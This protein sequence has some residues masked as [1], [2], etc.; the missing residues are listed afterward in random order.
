MKPSVEIERSLISPP[1]DTIQEHLEFIGMTQA[2][3]A[4][5][6]GR[7]KEK[8][9]DIIKG[10]EPI[11]MITAY[12]LENVL[13]IP[14]SFWIN[15]EKAYRMALYEIELKEELERQTAWLHQFPI[16]NMKRLG[17]LDD[18]KEIHTLVDRL[19]KFF[20]IASAAEWKK[21]YNDIEINATANQ[22]LA[23]CSNPYA[24][25]A[26]LRKGELQCLEL[27]LTEFDKTKFKEKL[28]DIKVK[29]SRSRTLSFEKLQK[30]C[31]ECGVALVQTPVLAK[32]PIRAAAR[33]FHK[34]PI[35]QLSTKFKSD[36]DFW[37]TFFHE[38]AH[39]LLHGK[40]EIFLED[41]LGISVNEVKE[42]E[43]NLYA[44]KSLSSRQKN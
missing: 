43:A 38:V 15:R 23:Y 2:E 7:P 17:W 13:G 37:L 24:I 31:A 41:V 14:A 40:K 8:I 22:Y 39:V 10:R 28:E 32:A 20:G 26:W 30:I 11:S 12:Q 3:L 1:G 9:N 35:I 16:N 21:I 44:Q 6:M 19:L 34:R 29:A 27:E 18:S 33:W 5:R 4:D 36:D 25:S 42:S